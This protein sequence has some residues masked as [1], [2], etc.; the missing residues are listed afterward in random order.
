MNHE[1]CFGRHDLR[2]SR[3]QQKI[4]RESNQAEFHTLVYVL[5]ILPMLV[6]TCSGSTLNNLFL[7]ACMP[8]IDLCAG[9]RPG[10]SVTPRVRTYLRCT[11]CLASSVCFPAFECIVRPVICFV[12][13][14][15]CVC[16]CVVW[17]Y[18]YT[19]L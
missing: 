8:G 10:R 16:V 2:K 17:V 7:Y 15:V 3:R 13:T 12:K 1:I 19:Y 5:V 6:S 4:R 11:N 9:H 18:D 14:S